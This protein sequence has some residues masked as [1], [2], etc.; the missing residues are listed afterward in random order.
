MKYSLRS[1]FLAFFMSVAALAFAQTSI[2]LGYCSDEIPSNHQSAVLSDANN[3]VERET[4][5][6]G[7][8]ECLTYIG[9][10]HSQNVSELLLGDIVIL[11]QLTNI[12]NQ[13]ITIKIRHKSYSS[14]L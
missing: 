14:R 2:H 3:L 1:L 13:N 7:F 8:A 6:V 4:L 12:L 10:G 9:L 11:H 5:F